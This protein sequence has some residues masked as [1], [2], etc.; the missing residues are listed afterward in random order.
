LIDGHLREVVRHAKFRAI[1]T[2]TQN[3]LEDLGKDVSRAL[4]NRCL[5]IKI[6]FNQSESPEFNMLDEKKIFIQPITLK[7]QLLLT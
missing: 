2:I 7:E 1:F 4:R 5:E 6:Q 3:S